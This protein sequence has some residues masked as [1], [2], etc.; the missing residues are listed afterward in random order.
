MLLVELQSELGE[1]DGDRGQPALLAEDDAPRRSRHGR[2][3]RLDRLGI[4]EL[5]R[6]RAALADEEVVA[7]ERLVRLEVVAGSPLDE[8]GHLGEAIEAHAGLGVIQGLDGERE[9]G[10]VHVACPLTHAVDRTLHPL[11][12]GA[13]RGDRPGNG[14]PEVVVAVPVDRHVRTNPLAARNHHRSGGFGSD[15]AERV[16][17]RH[18]LCPGPDRCLVH[19]LHERGLGAGAVDPEPAHVDVVLGGELDGGDDAGQDLVAVHPVGGQLAVADRRFDDGSL[20]AER[21]EQL[22]VGRDGPGESPDLGVE[23]LGHDQLIGLLVAGRDHWEPGF[24]AVD[25]QAV[26]CPGDDQFVLWGEHD[27]YG[28][29]AVAKRRVVEANAP[30]CVRAGVHR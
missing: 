10:D 4:V 23:V 8:C 20:H 6:N 12:S 14:Q 27:P 28:L 1:L 11:G 24:D 9:L 29:L 21:E 13:D 19:I 25:A 2:R 30:P 7:G 26:E 15:D 3:V 18:L 16:D 5:G 17:Q 22:D